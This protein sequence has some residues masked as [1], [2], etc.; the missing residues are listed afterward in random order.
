VS[1]LSFYIHG[2]S[3]KNFGQFWRF[4]LQFTYRIRV[5]TRDYLSLLV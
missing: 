2:I 4:T 3:L 1:N 5:L